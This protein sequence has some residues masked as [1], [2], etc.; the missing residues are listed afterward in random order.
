MV[1]LYLDSDALSFSTELKESLPLR[2]LLPILDW[3]Y[4]FLSNTNVEKPSN[5]DPELSSFFL[6]LYDNFWIPNFF[7]ID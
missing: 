4:F 2:V 7:K 6:A 5:I 1:N 3:F